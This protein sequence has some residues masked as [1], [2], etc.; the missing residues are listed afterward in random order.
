M[1]FWDGCF[2][3][4]DEPLLFPFCERFRECPLD[5]R[6]SPRSLERCRLLGDS[7]AGDADILLFV[8]LDLDG[9]LPCVVESHV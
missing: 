4:R 6:L 9:D 5:L 8:A 2:E 7:D 1:A 3:F